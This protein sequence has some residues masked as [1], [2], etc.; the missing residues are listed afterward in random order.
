MRIDLH[1]TAISFLLAATIVGGCLTTFSASVAVAGE[2]RVGTAA[3]KITPP[4]GTPMAGGYGRNESQG[5]LDDLYAKA[6]ILDDGHASVALVACDVIGLTRSA[7][8]EA[9][10]IIAE[11]TGIP[12]D[13]VMI[14]ATHT[15]TGPVVIGDSTLDDMTSGGS[16]LSKDFAEQLPKSIAQAVEQAHGRLMPAR[17][18]Y[19]QQDEPGISFIRR[20]WMKDG[21]IGWNPGQLNPNIIRPIGTI[22][23]QV[24]VVYA[25]TADKKPILTYVNFGMHACTTG[26]SKISAD[27][28]ASLASRL[29]D[30]KGSEMLT[31][32]A[33]GGARRRQ[34]LGRSVV[35]RA[36][37]SGGGQA[38]G[39]HPFRGRAEELHATEGGGQRHFADAKRTG[40]APLK[41]LHGRRTSHGPRY[42]RR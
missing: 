23:P 4:N 30:Y 14:S 40:A 25:E 32:Y 38:V 6:A 28:P 26:G 20:F 21:T 35:C 12:A 2:L 17:I 36:D 39:N 10:R 8:V 1:Q 27:F 29:A 37:K 13:H 34:S 41:A 15:H 24:N 7:V 33:D 16:Q 9:R 3:V 31:L 22:D 42:R 19:A 11:K 18:F 5:V